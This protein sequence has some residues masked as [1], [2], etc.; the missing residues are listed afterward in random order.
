[1]EH[2]HPALG[3]V[4][5]GPEVGPRVEQTFEVRQAAV[6]AAGD[7]DDAA[8]T[9]VVLGKLHVHPRGVVVEG[10]GCEGLQVQQ[11]QC[12]P[13]CGGDHTSEGAG[14]RSPA[15]G[16][17]PEVRRERDG[18]RGEHQE[19]QRR[20]ESSDESAAETR[21]EHRARE[22]DDADAGG[23]HRGL[24]PRQLAQAQS[25]YEHEVTERK[26]GRVE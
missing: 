3:E 21:D 12:D 25:V 2:H 15:R 4:Q 24:E 17:G 16:A 6:I 1:M 13:P 18:A 14:W 11:Q 8:V 9:R 26:H 7:R 20:G 23:E 19:R 22:G 5:T 10:V